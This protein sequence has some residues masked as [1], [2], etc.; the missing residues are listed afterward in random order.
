MNVFENYRPQSQNVWQGRIDDP[1][2]ID[3]FRWHQ[4]IELIDLSKEQEQVKPISK[5]TLGFCFLGFCCDK[6]VEGNL[7]RP[8][9]SKA[10]LSIRKEMANLPLR[11]DR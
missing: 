11:F 1:E 7:G 4:W 6:G 2:D 5:D 3:S 8:G 9:A 10:P